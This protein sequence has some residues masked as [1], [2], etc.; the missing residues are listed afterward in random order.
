MPANTATNTYSYTLRIK[1]REG[2]GEKPKLNLRRNLDRF[3]W[4]ETAPRTEENAS[5]KLLQKLLERM[6]MR[7]ATVC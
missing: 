4:G 6:N 3:A 5:G 1:K 7:E 2:L